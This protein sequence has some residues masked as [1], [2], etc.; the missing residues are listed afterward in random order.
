MKRARNNDVTIVVR[1]HQCPSWNRVL[2]QM[3]AWLL[4]QLRWNEIYVC[5]CMMGWISLTELECFYGKKETFSI[6]HQ[7]L[8]NRI[9]GHVFCDNGFQWLSVKRLGTLSRSIFF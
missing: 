4:Y 3:K 9:T 5:E 1:R 2:F 7:M 6:H 8:E